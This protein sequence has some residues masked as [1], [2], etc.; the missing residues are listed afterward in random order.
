LLKVNDALR[1]V[2]TLSV[3]PVSKNT[4]S[5]LFIKPMA[6]PAKV[7]RCYE[8]SRFYFFW[9]IFFSFKTTDTTLK[10]TMPCIWTQG[11]VLSEKNIRS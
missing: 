2:N 10:E 4:G 9:N 11:I 7:D 6:L 5:P 8:I 1:N 3:K